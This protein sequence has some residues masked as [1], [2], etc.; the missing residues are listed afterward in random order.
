MATL[1]RVAARTAAEIA[2]RFELSEAARPLLIADDPPA[3]FLERL[4]QKGYFIDAIRFLAFA[5][6]PREGIW[7]SAFSIRALTPELPEQ[8]GALLDRIEEWVRD[9]QDG[10]RRSIFEEGQKL[11]VD[12]PAGCLAAAVFFSAGSMAPPNAAAVP[13]PEGVPRQMVGGAV[14]LC[15]VAKPEELADRSR[16]CIGYGTALANGE[17]PKRG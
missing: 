14:I 9:P 5:L 3:A 8:D 1:T 11:G 7:W 16:Q 13:A 4:L 15:V 10:N 12:K 17:M 2:A 6:A